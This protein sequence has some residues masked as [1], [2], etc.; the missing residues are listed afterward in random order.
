MKNIL[1]LCTGNSCRSQMAHGYL[2]KFARGKAAVYSAGI[3]THGLNPAAVRIMAE[4]GIDIHKNTSNHVDEYQG[5]DWD[6]IIT[7]CDHA[8]ENCPYI[9]APRATRLHHNFNDPSKVTGSKEVIHIAFQQ[10]R[11]EIKNYCR[12]FATNY[13]R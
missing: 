6:Y 4:D 10:T 3:E 12:A 8:N 9:A 2:N 5:I 1:V 13:L 7:V 11:D